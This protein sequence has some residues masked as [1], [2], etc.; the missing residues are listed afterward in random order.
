MWFRTEVKIAPFDNKIDH[1]TT[2]LSMG[3]CFAGN[4][5]MKMKRA[6]LP[7]TDNPFGVLFNPISI[8]DNL[9]ALYAGRRYMAD[10]LAREGDVWSC[11]SFHG[12]FS[13]T[14]PQTAL[15]AMNRAAAEGEQALKDAGYV[16]ITFGTAWVFELAEDASE[17]FG[18]PHTSRVVANCHRF[19]AET[20][21]RRRL[22]VAE[23]VERYEM[24]F[25]T[26]LRGKQIIF[27]VSPVRHLKDGAAENTLSKAILIEAVHELVARHPS[28]V[29]FP[30]FEI[31]NDELRDYRFYADDMVHPSAVAVEYI[32]GKFR[33][34]ALTSRAA[35]AVKEVEKIAAAMD[36]RPLDPTTA[37]YREFLAII[38]ARIKE[39]AERYP[40]IDFSAEAEYFSRG[41]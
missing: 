27:T 15:Y 19:P 24:L 22:T 18:N 28:V 29:Y 11:F 40:E 5:A 38:S 9:E 3:S 36:H 20:F 16:I 1:S 8:A 10:D 37:A 25:N 4:M 7:V 35:V 32:W 34:A 26:A 14:D 17:N 6:K 2:G 33:D 21:R 39:L 13:S 12:S 23:I 41:E 31:M 30:A